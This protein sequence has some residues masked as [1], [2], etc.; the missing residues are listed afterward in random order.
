MIANI[1]KTA[2][3]PVAKKYWDEQRDFYSK[4]EHQILFSPDAHQEKYEKYKK[5][6]QGLLGGATNILMDSIG[7]ITA[8]LVD[9][10]LKNAAIA[11]KYAETA[12]EVGDLRQYGGAPFSP[13]YGTYIN[14][15]NIH[16]ANWILTGEKDENLKKSLEL[17]TI[18][19]NKYDSP[20]KE[21]SSGERWVDTWIYVVPYLIGGD[22]TQSWNL[23]K[24][25]HGNINI[26][27]EKNETNAKDFVKTIYLILE[28][29]AN[30]DVA[31]KISAS[32]TVDLFYY[33][34][35]GWGHEGSK[36]R[37]RLCER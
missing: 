9:M 14:T 34:I 2:I 4:E 36:P 27:L 10:G 3:D 17:L 18:V 1:G 11:K 35:T 21:Q 29:L 28:Y 13:E 6:K 19:R 30:K 8:G 22:F 37:D 12:L 31:I 15:V 7:Q 32:Q 5:N 20:K 25:I 24:L 16:N 23:F 26:N 33:N